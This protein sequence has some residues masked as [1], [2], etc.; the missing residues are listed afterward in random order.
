MLANNTVSKALKAE[1]LNNF[2]E[3]FIPTTYNVDIQGNPASETFREIIVFKFSEFFGGATIAENIGA[4]VSA[5]K[6]IV[7]EPVSIVQANC[8]DAQLSD[9]IGEVAYLANLI[10]TVMR[11]EAVSLR[12]NGV[13][14]FI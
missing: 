12:V 14:Y 9:R 11:Q 5:E 10:K 6:G 8:T 4:W 7:F 1:G 3:L 13:L 2:V